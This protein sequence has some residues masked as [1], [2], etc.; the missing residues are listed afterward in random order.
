[1]QAAML[2]TLLRNTI[3]LASLAACATF[4]SLNSETTIPPGQAFRL[5]GG[6]R[7]AFSVRGTNAGGVPVSV[8]LETAGKR[9]SVTT[10]LPGAEI[11]AEF[12]SG[13]VAIFRNASPASPAVVRIKVTGAIS[14]LGMRY[15]PNVAR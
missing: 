2:T 15:E 1:M 3:V 10:V 11:D 8:F 12:P 13:A 9:D 14:N 7:G 4:G 6:Q 5:G